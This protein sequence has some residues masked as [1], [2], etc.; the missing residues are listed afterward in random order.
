MAIETARVMAERAIL[1]HDT[2]LEYFWCLYARISSV[3][4]AGG[5][6]LGDRREEAKEGK[7]WDDWRDLLRLWS[8]VGGGSKVMFILTR[9]VG[10]ENRKPDQQILVCEREKN[11]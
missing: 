9:R 7:R 5:S 1:S 10:N 3:V 11:A 4:Y 8:T 6:W 2:S